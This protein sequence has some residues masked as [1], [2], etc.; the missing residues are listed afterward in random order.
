MR[1]NKVILN[2]NSKPDT[3]SF[4]FFLVLRI[5]K[6]EDSA[7]QRPTNHSIKFVFKEDPG[8]S[9]STPVN[10]TLFS[11]VSLL[12]TT[13]DLKNPAWRSHAGVPVNTKQ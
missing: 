13:L 2:T 3:S 9:L 4:S 1:V 6:F 10:K 8:N 7:S 11:L 5:N 12:S